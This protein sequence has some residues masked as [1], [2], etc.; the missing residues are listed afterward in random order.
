M[1]L[2]SLINLD[3]FERLEVIQDVQ[4]GLTAVIAIHNTKLGP[5]LGG[6]RMWNYPS[7]EDAVID[8]VR[9]ARG[10]TY[11]SAMA[12][13]PFGGGKAVVIGDPLKDKNEPL[14]RALGRFINRL[15]G[16]YITGMD[17]GTTSAD[18]DWVYKE[19]RYV[20][21]I[22]GSLGASG[23]FTADMTAYGVYLG[24]RASLKKLDGL[25]S[26]SGKVVAVQGLGKVG[27]FLCRYLAHA[28]AKLVV[29]D[30]NDELVQKAV[31][32]YGA[33][34]VG[35]N[36]IA[37]ELC[38]IYS[39]CALGGI[40]NDKSIPQLQCRIIA[41]AA[42]NQLAEERH[43]DIL[44]QRGILY[45]PDYV[46]NA[47][48]I[49]VTAAELNDNSP[50]YARNCVER[51]YGTLMNVFERSDKLGISAAKAANQLTEQLLSG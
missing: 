30:L 33:K 18:M 11:K 6:C 2:R 17:V 45:S 19:T 41:G 43:G 28:G 16:E 22:S 3:D 50:S 32:H 37:Q 4:S 31:Q 27:M 29:S 48:G 20:T 5:A 36:D 12:E 1:D 44:H 24:M 49:I 26:L 13:L 21:D 46:L 40:I 38:D 8:A 9:L 51:I 39:P 23:T 7:V 14:F 47:G 10:M 35:V 42:N 34:A 15:Q 25:E